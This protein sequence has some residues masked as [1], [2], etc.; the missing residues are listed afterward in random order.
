[1][2]LLFVAGAIVPH[3]GSR[4]ARVCAHGGRGQTG[5]FLARR[6]VEMSL[7]STFDNSITISGKVPGSR[8][9]LTE[10]MVSNPEAVI[11]ACWSENLI[12]KLGN[13]V[14]RTSLPPLQFLHFKINASVDVRAQYDESIDGIRLVSV[15]SLVEVPRLGLNEHTFNMKLT[16]HLSPIEKGQ[17]THFDGSADLEISLD[18]PPLLRLMP[19]SAINAAG[20]QLTNGVL[21][22]MRHNLIQNFTSAYRSWLQTREKGDSLNSKKPQSSDLSL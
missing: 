3:N 15:R 11:T 5:G 21:R 10:F 9:R 16:G 20:A 19:K 8:S 2:G 14:Y 1:M 17:R 4:G 6:Q 12:Q 22:S 18:L 13:G 7:R